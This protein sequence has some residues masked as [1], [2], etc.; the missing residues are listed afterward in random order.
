MSSFEQALELE[1]DHPSVLRNLAGVYL[2]RGN[3]SAALPLLRISGSPSKLNPMLTPK[4]STLPKAGT[5]P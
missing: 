2:R 3:A 5:K 1:S 4:P